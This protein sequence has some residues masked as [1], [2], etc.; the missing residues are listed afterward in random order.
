VDQ[1]VVGL[2]DDEHFL[3]D[4]R[5]GQNLGYQGKICIHPRQAELAHQV[6]TPTPDEVEHARAVVEAGAAGVAVVDGQMVDDV[7][8]RLAQAVLA[9]APQLDRS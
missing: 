5:G 4:A 8:V 2:A 3:A 7:H 1:A 9:R 6:F